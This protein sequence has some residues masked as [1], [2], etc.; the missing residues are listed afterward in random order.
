MIMAFAILH[1]IIM[2]SYWMFQREKA[3]LYLHNLPRHG[4]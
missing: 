3:W 2:F 1:V 4:G